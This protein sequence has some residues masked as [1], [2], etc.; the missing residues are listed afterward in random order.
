RPG[1]RLADRYRA[2]EGVLEAGLDDQVVR[3]GVRGAAGAFG[4]PGAEARV[5]ARGLD[6]VGVAGVHGVQGQGPEALPVRRFDAPQAYSLAG[7][8]VAHRA[9]PRVPRLRPGAPGGPGRAP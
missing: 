6:H 5:R 9:L 7:P 1:V 3:R 2:D 8:Q 4:G